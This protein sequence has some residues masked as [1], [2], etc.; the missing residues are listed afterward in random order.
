MEKINGARFL[1][2]G[3]A[4]FIGSNLCHALLKEGASVMAY[5]NLAT[6]KHSFIEDFEG[7]GL[8]FVKGDILDSGK[9][10][11]SMSEFK[12]DVVVHL[13]ANPN[14]KLGISNP[15]R[16]GLES[17][18]SVLDAMVKSGTKV[19]IFSSSG[20]VY[21]KD[22]LKPTPEDYSP[23]RPSSLYGAMKLGSEALISAFSN[24]YSLNY[25]IFRFA[26]VIGRN[27]THGVIFDLINKLKQNGRELH[28][29]GNGTQTKGYVNVDDVVEAVLYVYKKSDK[30]ENVFNVASDDQITVREIAEM[31]VEKVSKG[32]RII[33]GTT[34]EGWPG[35]I[36][37]NYISNA[38]LKAFGFTPR[39]TSRAAVEA[40]IDSILRQGTLG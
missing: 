40:T 20:S 14:V 18:Y 28:V 36:P 29:L 32:A 1:V 21:G 2:T 15:V 25:Y 34:R 22:A 9:L 23:M 27:A 7:N 5:D 26:N 12:P 11:S 4:G 24:L 35:D 6:G 33:Y 19:I 17:T 3:G 10:L 31:V 37:D 8:S 39:Y 13:A 16:E 38:K 30:R